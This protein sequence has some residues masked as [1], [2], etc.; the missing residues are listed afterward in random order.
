[1]PP[2]A[3]GEAHSLSGSERDAAILVLG[4]HYHNFFDAFGSLRLTGR[5]RKEPERDASC[6]ISVSIR[7]EGYR[8]G[9]FVEG[10]PVRRAQPAVFSEIQLQLVAGLDACE[11]KMFFTARTWRELR[12]QSLALLV[13]NSGT[14][15]CLKDED[16]LGVEVGSEPCG[17]NAPLRLLG[18]ETTD[19]VFFVA[20]RKFLW[21]FL[22]NAQQR[23][24]ESIRAAGKRHPDQPSFREA[25]RCAAPHWTERPLKAACVRRSCRPSQ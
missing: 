18:S 15:F 8:P 20:Y 25:A 23:V 9:S 16:C 5:N 12:D 3:A 6:E 14:T 11:K 13:R 17:W 22:N 24:N 21:S 19:A 10:L 2:P 7:P 1:M 4:S